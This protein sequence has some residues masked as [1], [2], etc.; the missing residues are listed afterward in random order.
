LAANALACL[1]AIDIRAGCPSYRW[2][3]AV[4]CL[5]ALVGFNILVVKIFIGS[6]LLSNGTYI[7]HP[8]G[9]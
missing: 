9:A 3:V 4:A 2:L 7:K 8:G 6:R 5:V 1:A